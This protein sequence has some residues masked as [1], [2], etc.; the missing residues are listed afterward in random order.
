MP[1][2]TAVLSFWIILIIILFPRVAN[3]DLIFINNPSFENDVLGDGNFTAS[4]NGWSISGTG[5]GTWNINNTPVFW[6]TPAPHGNQIGYA[7]DAS[8]AGS[9]SISQTLS[10]SLASNSEYTLDV[11]VGHPTGFGTSYTIDL[12]AGA[13][14][15]ATKSGIG[16]QGSFQLETLTFDSLG[17][18]FVGQPLGIRLYSDSPQTA[19]D[20]VSLSVTSVP[21]PSSLALAGLSCAFFFLRRKKER[22]MR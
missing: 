22:T 12:L 20:S 17:S 2:P 16:P 10:T 8:Q 4:I 13:N 18:A 6:N 3:A 15:L 19:F 11:F 5:G 21:E 7:T 9:A 14:V 1:K